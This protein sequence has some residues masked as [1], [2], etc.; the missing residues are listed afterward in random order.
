MCLQVH[1]LL[2]RFL[3]RLLLTSKGFRLRFLRLF[4]LCLRVQ[5][6]V[7]EA[8]ALLLEGVGNAPVL[9]PIPPVFAAMLIL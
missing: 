6:A 9:A 3:P 2:F 8:L 4:K 7:L 1:A 5:E